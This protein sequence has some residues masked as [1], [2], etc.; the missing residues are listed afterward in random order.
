MGLL[1]FYIK[2]PELRDTDASCKVRAGKQQKQSVNTDSAYHYWALIPS[3]TVTSA[4][5][6]TL[7]PILLFPWTSTV[8]LQNERH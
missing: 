7:S 1:L 4:T 6:P 3:I 2:M 5:E 8:L